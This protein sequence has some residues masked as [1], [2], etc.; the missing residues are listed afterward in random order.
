MIRSH[1]KN[2]ECYARNA[3]LRSS[4]LTNLSLTA[5]SYCLTK[6]RMPPFLGLARLPPGPIVPVWSAVLSSSLKPTWT[7]IASSLCHSHL[8]LIWHAKKQKTHFLWIFK[9]CSRGVP[10]LYASFPSMPGALLL[11]TFNARESTQRVDLETQV[12]SKQRM[13]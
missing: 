9:P 8:H 12:R 3:E 1:P 10:S 11:R 6:P 2:C 7:F 13:S 5:C 4:D